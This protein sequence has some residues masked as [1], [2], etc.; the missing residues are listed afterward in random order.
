[1]LR[2]SKRTDLSFAELIKN[3]DRF[4][5]II[6]MPTKDNKISVLAK[7][8]PER[9]KMIL[10]HAVNARILI[11]YKTL[12]LA[13]KFL[14][15]KIEFGTVKEKKVYENMST[16]QFIARLIRNR[17]VVFFDARDITLKRDGTRL[18]D[19]EAWLRVGTDNE[20]P[21][22]AMEEYLSYDE[23][24]LSALLIASSPT[25]F[26]NDGARNNCG[27]R[28]T[29]DCYPFEGVIMG[30]VGAR[31][32]K[33]GRM[34]YVHMIVDSIQNT[35]QNG[36]GEY[37]HYEY[38]N[39]SEAVRPADRELE[40]KRNLLKIWA[41][42]YEFDDNKILNHHGFAEY[43]SV[44]ERYE[45]FE[46]LAAELF[47][48]EDR[49][50][51]MEDLY[52]CFKKTAD[53]LKFFNVAVFKTRMRITFEMFLTDANLRGKM[54]KNP[55][56][57]YCH[58]VGL[59]LGVWQ[60]HNLQGKWIVDVVMDILTCNDYPHLSVLDFSWFPTSA[61]QAT[62][63]E[64]P[65]LLNKNL[66]IKFTK[67]NPY[68][69]LTGDDEGK[70]IC[71]MYAWD[72]NSFPGNEFW[73]SQLSASGDPAAACATT[74]AEL[75][76]PEINT[77]LVQNIYVI[78]GAQSYTLSEYFKEEAERDDPSHVH[79]YEKKWF[80]AS[81]VCEECQ[82][83]IISPLKP[84]GSECTQCHKK[85]HL[86]CVPAHVH[87]YEKVWLK[88]PTWCS[89][90]KVL[91]SG[92]FNPNAAECTICDFK[93]HFECMPEH[94]HKFEKTWFTKP[95]WCSL[96]KGFIQSPFNPNGKVCTICDVKI[97]LKCGKAFSRKKLEPSILNKK[98]AQLNSK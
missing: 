74:I 51:V 8:N 93:V 92:V 50:Q 39:N 48:D 7:E 75:Q 68:E 76:N 70:L 77:S 72:G 11:H 37:F 94:V 60:A 89:I 1:M 80:L 13:T 79:T 16:E 73:L 87:N 22:L 26:I 42:F 66:K 17:A 18:A 15:H 24:Q 57:V 55:K 95:T 10:D 44:K 52:L 61:E 3:S 88:T 65:R 29:K 58:V 62:S 25:F 85:V 14:M 5:Q 21:E 9:E 98:N 38:Q 30:A 54:S 2:D 84:N 59:G 4:S 45:T 32:E 67:N 19:C 12:K 49:E 63:L 46:N 40:I 36:Y 82:S 56:G 83:H 78:K 41:C 81:T 91:I 69:K 71:S 31:F 20:S 86:K 34:E 53:D 64:T 28:D 35:K 23:I 43:S 47:M 33:P 90:C 97:D 6:Q 27:V 96:C